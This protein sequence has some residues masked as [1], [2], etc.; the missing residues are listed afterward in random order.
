MWKGG[1]FK[2]SESISQELSKTNDFQRYFSLI[3]SFLFF[4]FREC[5]EKTA[6]GPNLQ[7]AQ[8]NQICILKCIRGRGAGGSIT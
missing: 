2:N 1:S 7:C 8:K 3:I 6:P 4:H 5:D